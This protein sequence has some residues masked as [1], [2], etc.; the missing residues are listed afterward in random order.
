MLSDGSVEGGL[1]SIL[2]L[3]QWEVAIVSTSAEPKITSEKSNR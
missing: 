3:G 1:S 2:Q